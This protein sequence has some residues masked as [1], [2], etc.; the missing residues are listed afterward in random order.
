VVWSQPA[1][2][3]HAVSIAPLHAGDG[4]KNGKKKAKLMGQHKGSLTE[5]QGRGQ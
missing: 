2:K 4:E 1:I 3:G 5:Q